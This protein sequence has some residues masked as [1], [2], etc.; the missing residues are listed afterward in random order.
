[1]AFGGY[2]RHAAKWLQST[3]AQSR[4]DLAMPSLKWF[5]SQQLPPDQKGPGNLDITA[6][7]AA[8]AAADKAFIHIKAFDLPPQPEKLVLDTAGVLKLGEV[9]AQSYRGG[10]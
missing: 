2:R 6:D 8:I 9:L 10:R 7:L 5:V 1:M 4:Q 3:V